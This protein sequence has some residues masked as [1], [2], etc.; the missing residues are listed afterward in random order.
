MRIK[1]LCVVV[2]FVFFF[3]C[4]S[5]LQDQKKDSPHKVHFIKA[6]LTTFNSPKQVGEWKTVPAIEICESVKDYSQS[7]ENGILWW[8]SI[9]YNVDAVNVNVNNGSHCSGGSLGGK[10]IVKM[11]DRPTE[12]DAT[13]YFH[14][15]DD[16]EITWAKIYLSKPI[17]DR[18]IA[19]ELGHS[20]GWLHFD[21]KDHIM[22][23]VL[24]NGGWGFEG[25]YRSN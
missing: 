7:I 15:N 1:H 4:T 9:G 13:T 8:E 16:G 14:V 12:K 25:L 5:E 10:I 20:F 3:G 21:K 17:D 23:S 11:F 24:E 6:N 19:H 22:N 2:S 18:I